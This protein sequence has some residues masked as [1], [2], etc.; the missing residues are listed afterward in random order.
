M[1]E[2]GPTRATDALA[3]SSAATLFPRWPFVRGA[4][5]TVIDTLADG[6]WHYL[7]DVHQRA[8]VLYG[9]SPRAW[10]AMLTR[11]LDSGD[12]L[13]I[14]GECTNVRDDRELRRVRWS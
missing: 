11:A 3:V 9:L 5:L 14:R 8:N 4:Y 2:F 7:Q 12:L 1:T 6:H 13:E 10:K